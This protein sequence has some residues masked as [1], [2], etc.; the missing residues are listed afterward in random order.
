MKTLAIIGTFLIVHF[1]LFFILSLV[2]VMW[3]ESYSDI[4]GHPG[5]FF[6]YTLFIGVWASVLVCKEIYDDLFDVM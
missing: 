2:G 3:G 5:W 1:G 4:I 6:T